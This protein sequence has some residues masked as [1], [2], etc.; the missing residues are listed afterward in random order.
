M[1]RRIRNFALASFAVV[2]LAVFV[3]A[4]AFLWRLSE[5]PVSLAFLKDTV[6]QRINASLP[7]VEISIENVV[8]ERDASTGQPHLRLQDIRFKNADGR[9]IAQAPRA[10]IQIKGWSLLTGEVVP[11]ALELIG[12]RLLIQRRVDGSIGLGFGT[13]A[14]AL[15]FEGSVNHLPGNKAEGPDLFEGVELLTTQAA[16]LLDYLDGSGKKDGEEATGLEKINS[17]RI[18]K[19]A[20]TLYDEANGAI[21]FSPDASL[22]F[23][24]APY[25]FALFVDGNIAGRNQ[26][27]RM[28]LTA[29]YR[30]DTQT[31]KVSSRVFDVIPAEIARDVFALSQLAQVQ[32]PLSGHVEAEFTRT[33]KMT[34]ASAEFSAAAGRV[35]FPGY[36]SEPII[37]DEGSLR[38][39]FDPDTGDIVIGDSAIFIGGSTAQLSGRLKPV[40][41]EKG[42]LSAV[43]IVLNAKNVAIDTAGTVKDPVMFNSV[44]FDG[45]AS[46]EK[47]TLVVNDLILMSGSAGIRVRGQFIGGKE[48]A[49]VFLAG[50]IRDLPAA[51]IKKMWPPVVAKGARAWIAENVISGRMS[52]GTFRVAIPAETIVAASR[53]VPIPDE[54]VDFKFSLTDVTSRYFE[55]LP[56]LRG[57]SGT[58]VLTGN[59]FVLDVKTGSVQLPN[60]KIIKLQSARMTSK[61]LA[62]PITPST[63]TVK[64]SGDAKS[65]LALIDHKPLNLLDGTGI[66]IERISGDASVTVNLEL[67]LSLK[68]R[69]DEITVNATARWQNGTFK[70]AIEGANITKGDFNISVTAAEIVAKGKAIVN[71]L[72]SEVEWTQPFTKNKS[73]SAKLVL[74]T[75]VTEKKRTELGFDLSRFVRGS[76]AL[77]VIAETTSGD[78]TSA[79]IEADL[80]KAIL[81]LSE[82][83]WVHPA[84]KKTRARFDLTTSNG[85]KKISNLIVTGGNMK[86]TGSI[87]LNKDGSLRKAVFPQFRLDRS[88]DMSLTAE[89]KGQSISIIVK[90]RSFDARKLINQAFSSRQPAG[91]NAAQN[92]ANVAIKINV[93]NVI[94]NRGEVIR[95][96]KGEIFAINGN[97]QRANVRGQF[98][99]GAPVSLQIAPNQ[100]KGRNLQFTSRNAGAALRATNL[101]SKIA[102]GSLT[103]QAN[104]AAAPKTGIEKGLLVLRNFVVRNESA[105]D[106]IG[107][108]TREKAKLGPRRNGQKFK[109]LKLPFSTDQQFVN[110]GDAL[111][112]GSDLGASANG[113]IRKSDGAMDVAGTII[114]AYAI[115]SAVSGV[116]LLGTILT[117]GKG[118][119]VF[120]L[121]YALQGTMNKPKFIVNPVSA[122]AP[123]FLRSLFAIGGGGNIGSDGTGTKK[124]RKLKD[125]NDR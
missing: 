62:K 2:L 3:I 100:A 18:T 38:L 119:G 22:V 85:V 61:D 113:R 69:E 54:M 9:L 52:Q 20:I 81:V 76:V 101:Y 106:T 105:L 70:N 117:G 17:V 33:G 28:E 14:K 43:G 114:P 104:L 95:N 23:Q 66:K 109:K 1:G 86:I 4:A 49:G 107:S 8:I 97:V 11:Q 44:K 46:I 21:W 73:T 58:G 125:D 6:E 25:G 51:T 99:G 53:D 36:I 116:P 68:M 13:S 80:S 111:V 59:T 77:K 37:I 79:K 56:V 123:G 75:A 83:D 24:R 5:G 12:A 47:A 88:N 26:P 71:G 115:N 64:T 110:I 60:K 98:I 30:N 31:F 78:V 32:I 39:D 65:L 10:A 48:A 45:L 102:G 15:D 118:Q 29:H 93:A 112:R 42:R 121:T 35:G 27:W 40:R 108:T 50:T 67:P 103:L 82:I 122:L 7:E 55:E 96:V 91:G 124:V 19:T 84:G 34:R 90:G 120:G 72:P 63:I 16:N 74:K 41:N 87:S 94:A 92:Q 57:A 89:K